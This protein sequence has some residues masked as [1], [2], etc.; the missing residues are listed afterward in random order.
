MSAVMLMAVL[1]CPAKP[2]GM[3]SELLIS[4]SSTPITI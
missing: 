3:L 4:T 1:S 2:S